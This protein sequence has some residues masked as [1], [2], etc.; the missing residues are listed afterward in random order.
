MFQSAPFFK[1]L[2]GTAYAWHEVA[3]TLT[4]NADYA[5]VEQKL[6]ATVNSVYSEYQHNIDRQHALVERILD[7]TINVPTPKA[8][9][10]FVDAG[11]ELTVRYPVEIPHAAEVDDK[12]TREL[13][14]AISND[15]ELKA[16]V[17]G[18]PALR[19]AI[20]A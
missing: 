7:A 8:Q 19:A 4:P 11:L 6:L 5:K 10:R 3:I 13:M 15:P 2:P 18:S 9:L 1:Q 16:A 14:K 17:T 12:V 20:K